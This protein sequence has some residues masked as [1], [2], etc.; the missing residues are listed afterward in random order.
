MNGGMQTAY[1]ADGGSTYDIANIDALENSAS[2]LANYNQQL[3]NDIKSLRY[4]IKAVNE[5]WQ[6]EAGN[7]IQSIMANLNTGMQTLCDNIQPVIGKY[8]E[9]LNQM[10]AETKINQGRSL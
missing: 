9:T 5:N 1:S 8:V 7:D 4:V 10:V 2:N 3:T 6:N